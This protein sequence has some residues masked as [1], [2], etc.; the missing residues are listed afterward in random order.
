MHFRAMLVPAA[1]VLALAGCSSSG[2]KADFA[3]AINTQLGKTC[4][5]LNPTRLTGPLMGGTTYPLSM[6]FATAGG[7]TSKAEA[8][9]RNK[10]GFGPFDALVKAG[11]LTS[12]KEDVK[13]AYSNKK[14]PGKVYSLT[15]TG[16]TYLQK[17]SYVAFCAGHYKVAEVTN[18][19]TP[20]KAIDG[21]TRSTATFTYVADDVPAWA[22]K[23]AIKAEFPDFY[24]AVTTK[25]QGKADLVKMAKGWQASIN[26]M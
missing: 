12:K 16:E 10:R 23:D 7:W 21:K 15:P 3:K 18:F 8:E 4:L 25:Q 9:Q 13:A 17:K 22:S 14:V 2:G 24:K 26:R 19:T 1:A 11:L 5:T 6:S 20:G